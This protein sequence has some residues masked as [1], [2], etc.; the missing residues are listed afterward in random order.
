MALSLELIGKHDDERNNE[1]IS[2]FGKFPNKQIKDSPQQRCLSVAQIFNML[3]L[4]LL[5][6]Q[7]KLPADYKKFVSPNLFSRL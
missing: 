1:E 7:S 2:L 5:A 6:Q 3:R 4:F